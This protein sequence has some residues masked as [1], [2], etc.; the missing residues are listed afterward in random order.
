MSPGRESRAIREPFQSDQRK[1]IMY[2]VQTYT[3]VVPPSITYPTTE[4]V[5][6]EWSDLATINQLETDAEE[7]AEARELMSI[8]KALYT[9]VRIV[10]S[11]PSGLLQHV[12][13]D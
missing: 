7:L 13:G 4:I 3:L 2:T 12:A 8:A 11:L 1:T 5:K 6:E 9:R 10:K